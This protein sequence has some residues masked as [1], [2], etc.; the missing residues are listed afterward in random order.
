MV[1]EWYY[2]FAKH[3]QI[4]WPLYQECHRRSHPR[5]FFTEYMLGQ[6]ALIKIVPVVYFP[7]QTSLGRAT[8]DCFPRP[9]RKKTNLKLHKGPSL[10][11]QSCAKELEWS[12]FQDSGRTVHSAEKN[13][14]SYK[15]AGF[16]TEIK[17]KKNSKWPT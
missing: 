7:D 3:W 12:L 9:A 14:T 11:V 4:Q 1:A 2:L 17:Q 8:I 6:Q 13:D 5:P 15:R 16:F 10:Y